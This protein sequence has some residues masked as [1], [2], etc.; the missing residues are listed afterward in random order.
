M[1]NVKRHMREIVLKVLTINTK[2]LGNDE[3]RIEDEIVGITSGVPVRTIAMCVEDKCVVAITGK[4]EDYV[5]SATRSLF[6]AYGCGNVRVEYGS[7]YE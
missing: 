2:N 4:D 6:E 5:D 1:K 7:K 3:E